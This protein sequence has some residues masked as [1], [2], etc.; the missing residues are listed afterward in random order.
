MSHHELM[1]HPRLWTLAV[2]LSI[3]GGA[4]YWLFTRVERVREAAARSR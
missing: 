4:G 1:V 2:A 3:L